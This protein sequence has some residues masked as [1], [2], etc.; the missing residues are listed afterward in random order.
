GWGYITAIERRLGF[1]LIKRSRGGK[2]G[3]GSS[4]T[5]A[6][7]RL[8]QKFDRLNHLTSKFADEKFMEI[9]GGKDKYFK[10]R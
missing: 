6:A 10:N 5:P 2:N 9:F 1:K 8:L 7:R 4:L 3:G